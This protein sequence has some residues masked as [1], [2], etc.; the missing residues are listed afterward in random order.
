MDIFEKQPTLVDL[1][2]G[3]GGTGL[4][5][6]QAG[7]KI[8]GAVE[9]DLNSIATYQ[10]NLKVSVTNQDIRDLLPEDFRNRLALNREELD[11]LAGCPPCQGF[12]RMRND[13]GAKDER[14]ELVLRYLEYVKEFMPRYAL[15]ENV[16]G[17]IR[18]EHGSIFYNKLIS[19]LEVLGYRVIKNEIDAVNYGVAQHR[20]RI[21]VLAGRDGEVPPFP[22]PSY[23]DPRSLEV[24]RGLISP[25]RTVR[26]EIGNER[27][28]KLVVGQNGEL[29]GKYPN[30]ISSKTGSDV[31]RF[32]RM[33]PHDGGS[34]TDVDKAFWL[35]CHIHHDGHKD[36]Y[37]RM[38]WDRPSNTITSG[39][40]NPSKGRFVHPNQDRA[41][42]AR[43]A[44]TLQGF[45]QNYRFFGGS[46]PTQIGNAVPP[47]LAMA[48]ATKL[49]E[50]L[51]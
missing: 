1:F 2:S 25:W 9:I 3:A 19:G 51:L 24:D 5:F 40:T 35:P 33:V 28:P 14:N 11:V 38:S 12:T 21:I 13:K 4:G 23:G 49:R 46:V 18:T 16:S 41:I 7:F 26:I 15:F 10:N 39:C 31:L 42:T 37:G 45:P 22:E 32:I 47:P 48:I 30:H 8:V 20:K 36:V 43:E 17:L 34:R 29:D 44:A 50:S 27:F 6:V